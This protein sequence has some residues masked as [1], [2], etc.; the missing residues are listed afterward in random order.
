MPNFVVRLAGSTRPTSAVFGSSPPSPSKCGFSA[1]DADTILAVRGCTRDADGM[2][3]YDANMVD[4][5]TYAYFVCD[6]HRTKV[7]SILNQHPLVNNIIFIPF[8]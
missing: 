7:R 4:E 3:T 6:N 2:L 8:I 5:T 1:D